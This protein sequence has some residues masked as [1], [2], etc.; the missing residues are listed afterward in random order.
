[1]IFTKNKVIQDYCVSTH[2]SYCSLENCKF[3]LLL[4]GSSFDYKDWANF[5]PH[6]KLL[7]VFTLCT[8]T[9]FIRTIFHELAKFSRNLIALFITTCNGKAQKNCHVLQRKS[10]CAKNPNTIIYALTRNSRN[11]WFSISG[12]SS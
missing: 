2:N 8:N 11:Y 7:I 1:M 6:I 5:I 12:K 10:C 4:I 9:D 3:H